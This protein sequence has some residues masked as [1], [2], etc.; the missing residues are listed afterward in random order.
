MKKTGTLNA[1]L[2]GLITSMGHGDRLVICD[3][4]LPIPRGSELIDLALRPGVPGFLET[5]GTVLEELE[6]ESAVIADEMRGNGVH[7]GL[8]RLLDGIPLSSVSHEGFR[9]LTRENGNIAF[10][11]TGETTPYANVMLVAGVTFG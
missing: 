3:A 10:V 7:G 2:S 5:V 11:R 9:K 4:G 1:R 8:E 6:V